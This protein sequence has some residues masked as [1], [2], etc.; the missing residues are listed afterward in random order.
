MHFG[1]A[2]G[3]K[4]LGFWTLQIAISEGKIPS[5]RSAQN[6]ICPFFHRPP[7]TPG[8]PQIPRS[9]QNSVCSFFHRLPKTPSPPQITRSAQNPVCPF[10]SE[11]TRSALSGQTGLNGLTFSL[12]HISVDPSEIGREFAHRSSKPNGRVFHDLCCLRMNI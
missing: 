8:P 10:S 11:K 12:V 5:T 7:K 4:I 3:A 6:R 1:R 2:A 9:A